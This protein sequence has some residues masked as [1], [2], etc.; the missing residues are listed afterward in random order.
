M[1]LLLLEVIGLIALLSIL[2]DVICKLISSYILRLKE[3][4][5]HG[6][7]LTAI[8]PQHFSNSHIRRYILISSIITEL[9]D[10]GLIEE[11]T[12]FLRGIANSGK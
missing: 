8:S 2:K 5:L 10:D 4:L 7:I 1:K 9:L 6:S 11:K 3:N 12:N